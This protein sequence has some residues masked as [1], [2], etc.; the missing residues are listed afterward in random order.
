MNKLTRYNQKLLAIIGTT[1]IVAAG[2]TLLIGLGGLLFSLTDFSDTDDN[3]IRIQN[4]T[5]VANDSV[6]FVRTQEVTFNAPSQ[7]D[8]AQT[9]F[10][11]TV[12]QVNLETEENV[13][14]NS[15]RGLK[16]SSGGYGYQSYYG[17][18]NNFVYIDY[19]KDLSRKLFD[20]QVAIT[21][22]AFLKNGSIEVL[23]F[24]GT[25]TDDNLDNQMDSN[26]YQSLF[27]YY[28]ND[29]QLKQYDFESKT[30]LNFDPMKK[31]DLV[32]IELGIDKDQD[33]N[34]ESTSEPQVISA[35]NIRTRKIEPIVSDEMKDE[36]QGIIDGRVK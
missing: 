12:G 20:Q 25:S 18:F 23:L 8:T 24:K 14:F 11:V 1:I 7:L 17:L 9:K 31:T 29:Q 5:T 10:I 4:P 22:W 2:L 34:F 30:V 6:E 16:F 27:A 32:S 36:I 26:D 15:G 21:H 35:L 13:R 28:L 3:G 19:S 33:F